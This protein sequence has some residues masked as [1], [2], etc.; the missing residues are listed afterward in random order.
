M[1]ANY[2]VASSDKF[3]FK[4]S[5]GAQLRFAWLPKTCVISG[6]RI[7]L[8]YGYRMTAMYHAVSFK[9]VFE[10]KWFTKTEYLIWKLKQ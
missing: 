2:G 3:F 4:N 8:T 7:W 1:G 10:H 6:K 9:P 5:I